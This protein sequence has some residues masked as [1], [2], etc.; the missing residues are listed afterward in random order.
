MTAETLA[1]Q[2]A[3]ELVVMIKCM[4]LDILK[5]EYN[6]KTLPIKCITDSKSL[7]DA[8]YSSKEVTEKRL[9]IELC[10][11]RES[12]GKGEVTS[13]PWTNSKNQ[14]ADCLTKEGASRDKLYDAL[15][16]KIKL[17]SNS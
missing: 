4:L 7:H 13:V 2:E 11:I 9:K 8:V 5:I 15:S 17:Y 16:E 1:L 3:I 10:A 12:L 14:L 6:N